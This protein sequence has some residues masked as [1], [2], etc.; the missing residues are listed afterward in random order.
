MRRS[1]NASSRHSLLPESTPSSF[2]T[3]LWA[4]AFKESISVTLSS[5]EETCESL[6]VLSPSRSLETCASSSKYSGGSLGSLDEDEAVVSCEDEAAC[7]LEADLDIFPRS[8]TVD[9]A[10]LSSRETSLLIVDVTGLPFGGRSD[11]T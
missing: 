4:F 3:F 8:P 7:D 10:G 2:D 1:L 11:Q 9:S 5:S 6:T